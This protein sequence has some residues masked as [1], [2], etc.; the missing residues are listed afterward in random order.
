METNTYHILP[1]LRVFGYSPFSLKVSLNSHLHDYI[2]DWHWGKF[3]FRGMC[4][5]KLLFVALFGGPGVYHRLTN[6][7]FLVRPKISL[8]IRSLKTCLKFSL[9]FPSQFCDLIS[10]V[11][12]SSSSLQMWTPL[13]SLLVFCTLFIPWLRHFAVKI[14][15]RR[16][17]QSALWLW[18]ISAVWLHS[19]KSL[20][21]VG[22]YKVCISR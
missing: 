2:W 18:I 4:H 21:S 12:W 16:Y 6:K 22:T 9:F 5:L 14:W 7:V 13:S 17:S 19:L 1:C 10:K 3:H 15:E 8:E 20:N 11:L